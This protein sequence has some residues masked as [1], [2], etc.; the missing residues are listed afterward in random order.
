MMGLMELF[1]SLSHVGSINLI[2]RFI[3]IIFNYHYI[4]VNVKL[5]ACP[6]C[7]SFLQYLRMLY[8]L[9]L[10]LSFLKFTA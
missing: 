3:F 2:K 9:L 5:L 6:Y 10:G 4:L 7:I 1:K 8:A